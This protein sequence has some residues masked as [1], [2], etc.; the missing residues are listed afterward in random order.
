MAGVMFAYSSKDKTLSS[1]DKSVY[2]FLII[3]TSLCLG[4]NIAT[5]LKAMMSDVRWWVLSLKR[6]ALKEVDLIL[7]CALLL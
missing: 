2:N 3:G 1:K 6:R 5:S 4:M 7:V